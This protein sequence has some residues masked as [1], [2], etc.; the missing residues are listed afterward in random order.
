M[1]TILATLLFFF[2]VLSQGQVTVDGPIRMTGE[3][4]ERRIDGLGLPSS[5]DAAMAV[6]ASL[7]GTAH[8]AEAT[9]DGPVISLLPTVPPVEYRGGQLFRFVA[10]IE[11]FG[12][13]V[14]ACPS[15]PEFPVL[16]PDGTAPAR[17][18]MRQGA[19]CEVLFAT[20][21]WI[22]L[23][24]PERG[25][26][27]GTTA[28][29]DRLC[30]ETVDA[31]N[32]FFY[33]AAERCAGMGGKLC[34]WDDFYIACTQFGG[35][36]SGLFDAWEWLDDSSNHANSAVQVGLGTCTAQRWANPQ[37]VTL[38]HSRCCFTLR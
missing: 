24:A 14:L 22:L 19:V 34:G 17:G 30:I 11:L 21:K 8:W 37:S 20:D 13:L 10:P 5:P 35:Q 23:N 15:L 4:G 18:Q 9:V 16:R 6:E 12:D 28:V 33:A 29:D 1:R 2:F 31:G 26:P 25:C 27:P 7:L 32:L 38:G 3:V 36:L